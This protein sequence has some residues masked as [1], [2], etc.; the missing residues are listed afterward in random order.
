MSDYLKET[1]SQTAG[2]FV[3]IGLA[4]GLQALT[5]TTKNWAVISLGQTRLANAFALR[6]S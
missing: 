4:P 6:V 3:H 1:P 2:P 5:S